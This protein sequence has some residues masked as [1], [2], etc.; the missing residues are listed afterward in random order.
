MKVKKAKVLACI[1][2]VAILVS[3]CSISA[4]ASKYY[5]GETWQG[6]GW[7]QTGQKYFNA[8]PGNRIRFINKTFCSV[9]GAKVEYQL[10][11][12]PTGWFQNAQL[13]PVTQIF[14]V[15]GGERRPWWVDCNIGN[16]SCEIQP[17]NNYISANN[18][19]VV[20]YRNV[21]YENYNGSVWGNDS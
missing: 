18:R 14:G 15:N 21:W 13:M 12:C 16:Y 1:S 19:A 2:A 6:T 3:C 5:Y 11:Y 9:S 4:S 20:T 10:Y 17:L 8:S 7:L